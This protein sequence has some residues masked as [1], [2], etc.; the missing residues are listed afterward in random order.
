MFLIATMAVQFVVSYR[1]ESKQVHEHINYQME[2]AQKDVTFKLYRLTDAVSDLASYL[3]Q[4]GKD[5]TI[6]YDYIETVLRRFPD[7]YSCYFCYVPYYLT[8]RDEHYALCALR[9][10]NDSVSSYHFE[11]VVDYVERDWYKGAMESDDKGYWAQSYHDIDTDS[12][13]FTYSLKA[14]DNYGKVIGVAAADYTLS[15]AKQLLQNT[16]PY[17]DAVCQLYDQGGALIVQSG[18]TNDWN[19]MIVMERA[20]PPTKMELVIGVPNHH[21]WDGIIKTS[22]ITFIAL[23]IGILIA[24]LLISRLWKDQVA[25]SI[26]ETENKVLENELHIASNIQK[27]ILRQGN[28]NKVKRE[29]KWADV[30][31]QAA[32]EPMREVGGDLY[33]FYRK[34]DDLYFIIGD[35]S[36]K[37]V[38]A[39]IFMSATVNLFRSAVRRLQSP[40]SIM[41]DINSVLSDNNPSMMFVTAFVGR[42]HIPTGEVLYC[43]A[44]HVPPL[45]VSMGQL[46]LTISMIPNIPLGYDGRFRFEEQ[47]LLLGK[48]EVFVLYTDGLT[49]ARNERHEMLGMQRWREMVA[50]NI[51]PTGGDYISAIRKAE[52]QFIGKAEQADDMTLMAIRLMHEVLPLIVR[53]DNRLDQWPLLK[54][55]MHD[56]ALCAGLNK[57]AL[58]RLE[59]ALEEAVVNVVNYSQAEWIALRVEREKEENGSRLRLTLTDNGVAFDPTKQPKADTAQMA[60]KRQIGGLG[61]A[62][63]KQIADTLEYTRH[64]NQNILIIT[65]IIEQP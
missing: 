32:L 19:K 13:I 62:L 7:L 27:S 17:K 40:K 58:N 38:T 39:A 54:K 33:D 53:V 6:L 4:D 57:R 3:P 26:M 37:S 65:K 31:L 47:G 35:V 28:C 25:F 56:Y 16:R 5:T 48:D 64:D 34:G 55:A 60:A 61:I 20:L 52:I 49:E 36:G 50:K 15:W 22:L 24:G 11:D 59:M 10:D 51:S 44:G 29:D 18:E 42:L 46:P 41:E 8:Q 43:N 9:V 45:F 2:L 63:L 12:L 21:L 30:E 23:V 1:N 14:Y